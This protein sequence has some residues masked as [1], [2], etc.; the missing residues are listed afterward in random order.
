[1]SMVGIYFY[2]QL[3]EL[4]RKTAREAQQFNN[5]NDEVFFI[6]EEE[7]DDGYP[8]EEEYRDE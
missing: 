3:M 6:P 8:D 1:M 7:D 4:A 2:R 5:S